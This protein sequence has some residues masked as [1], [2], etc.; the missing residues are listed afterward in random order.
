MD[1]EKTMRIDTK[2]M[3]VTETDRQTESPV[4]NAELVFDHDFPEKKTRMYALQLIDAK[5]KMEVVLDLHSLENRKFRRLSTAKANGSSFF[6]SPCDRFVAARVLIDGE[7][8]ILIY[9]GGVEPL[10][11]VRCEK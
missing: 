10:A 2:D 3:S 5:D 9:D 8:R 4:P 6:P 1:H 7:T 11:D